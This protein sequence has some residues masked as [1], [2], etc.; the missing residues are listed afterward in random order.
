MAS[1]YKPKGL[2]VYRIAYKGPDGR[3]LVVGGFKDKAASEA[4]AR[5]LERDAERA[6]AGLTVTDRSKTFAQLTDLAQLWI[7]E[8]QRRGASPRHWR[9]QERLLAKLWE[10]TGWKTLAAVRVDGFTRFLA[11]LQTAGRAARTM[12]AFRHAAKAFCDFCV[13]QRWLD[14]N[15]LGR[16]PKAR[17][18]KKRKRR[19]YTL[20]E[21]RRLLDVAGKRKTVY[22]IAA[23]SGLR[24]DELALTERRDL[25]PTGDRP[26]WHWRAEIVKGRRL[27]RVPIMPDLLPT[28]L[29]LWQ[30]LPEPTGRL[31]AVPMLRTLNR[32]LERAGIPKVDGEGRTLDFHSFR[33]FF[34]TLLARHLPI[35]IVRLL[36]RHRTIQQTC[37][38]YMDLGLDDASEA[39]VKLPPLLGAAFGAT[40]AARAGEK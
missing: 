5:Q 14:E 21:F 29:P 26:L 35:Q 31:I 4:K 20:D 30:A 39:M 22:L 38:L 13:S 32:D 40:A 7:A 9:E 28:L 10:G 15:P 1:V 19:A 33:Y 24:R 36:M 37:D 6:M 8:L 2:N 11:T 34:C 27:D 17:G 16:V 18:G 25:T 23:L 12:N 3:R